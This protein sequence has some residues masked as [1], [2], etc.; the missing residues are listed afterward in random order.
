MRQRTRISDKKLKSTRR[1]KVLGRRFVNHLCKVFL[2][3]GAIDL[4]GKSDEQNLKELFDHALSWSKQ[5]PMMMTVDHKDD[6][7]KQARIFS[8]QG[9]LELAFLFYAT[10]F[11]HWVNHLLTKRLK[12]ISETER[13]QML[14][15]TSLR[16]KLTWLLSLVHNASLPARHI[17]LILRVSE[18]RNSF[19]HY[20]FIV[21]DVDRWGES[22]AQHQKDLSRIEHTIAF[23]RRF[24]AKLFL[25]AQAK[26]LIRKLRDR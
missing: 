24:E 20:K 5:H 9:R 12:T 13:K 2:E 16:G 17:D 15:E 25:S 23:L 22:K 21:S 10:W 3:E 18:V 1:D 4:N 14:R 11:E 26:R 6:L 7:I 19:V 8:K